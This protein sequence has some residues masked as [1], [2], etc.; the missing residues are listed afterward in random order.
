MTAA[1]ANRGHYFTP[2]IL[3]KVDGKDITIPEF[4][5]LKQTTID[6][7]HFEPIVRGMA[8][9]YEKGTAKWVRIPDIEI[10]GKTG[11]VE[12]FT[13]IDSVKTQ[14]TDHSVFVAFAP[15]NKPEIAIA[16]YIENGYYGARYAGHIASLMIEKYI[17][18][19]ITRKDLERR[20]L[21]K[22]LEHEYAKPY[23]GEEFKIN[24]YVW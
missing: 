12:N 1:I 20:M 2:H 18:G 4:T 9:V 17:K 8:N 15:V 22:T 19:V 23:S 11:T 14:L 21:E 10:A 6:R 24:E 7:R 13:I 16:V 3:K 5:E